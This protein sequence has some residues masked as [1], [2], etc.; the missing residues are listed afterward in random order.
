VERTGADVPAWTHDAPGDAGPL[1]TD[2]LG[3]GRQDTVESSAGIIT[4]VNG[5]LR[6]ATGQLAQLWQ[7][8]AKTTLV[9]WALFV[10]VLL[11]YYAALTWLP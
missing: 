4:S 6:A 8:S 3:E 11:V 5:R 9:S 10:S 1:P 2:S 7:Y